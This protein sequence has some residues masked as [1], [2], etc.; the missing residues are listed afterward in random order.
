MNRI[1][2]ARTDAIGDLILTLPVLRSI[3]E[4]YPDSEV[5]LL[6]SDYTRDL[7]EN[8]SYIDH[9]LTIPGRSVANMSGVYRL[10][11]LLREHW[12]D[13]GILMYPRFGLTLALFLAGIP[14]RAGSAYRLYSFLFS[15]PVRIHRRDSGKH[16]LDLNYELAEAVLPGLARHEPRLTV[17]GEQQDRARALLASEDLPSDS[18]YIVIHP[19]SRGSAPNWRLGRYLDLA[20]ELSAQGLPVIF[21]GSSSEG[22]LIA[23]AQQERGSSLINL[24][25]KTDLKTLVGLISGA[26]L[27]VTGST[28]P[29]HI[30][31]AVSTF[32]VGIYPPQAALSAA[33][34]GPRGGTNKL[35][36]PTVESKGT[37]YD[38]CMDAIS[39]DTVT[40]Y[41]LSKCE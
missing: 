24:A 14:I 31:S 5:D 40:A 9:L 13:V 33:R 4:A 12:Y 6:S 3:K 1:L 27:L 26:K 2:L 36:V 39:V 34:W 22:E 11:E 7:L 18:P 35:F 16:E 41:V 20:A 21:S 23:S 15:N 25:G 28:G 29:I 8:E 30:A 38:T 17:S 32:A 10:A 37:D 19:L